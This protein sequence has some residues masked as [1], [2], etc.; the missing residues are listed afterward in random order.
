MAWFKNMTGVP[1]IS[2][3]WVE[4][5]GQT[6]NDPFSPLNGQVIPNLNGAAGGAD[7]FSNSKVAVYLRG[8]AT[9][10][11]YTAD[12]IKAH[13]HPLSSNGSA[14][15]HAHASTGLTAS[16]PGHTHNLDFNSYNQSAGNVT[17]S[18]SG[19]GFWQKGGSGLSPSFSV[20]TQT[21]AITVAGT[22][23]NATAIL[24]GNTDNFGAATETIPKTVTAVM[25]MRV[26]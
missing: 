26:K 7:T 18:G 3:G 16:Q 23:A 21:P 4:C 5:N 15:N 17:Q 8:G 22:T 19:S 6:L 14:V 12:A 10:G 13:N 1:V 2:Y 9:S 11:T 24:S 25:I 20:D